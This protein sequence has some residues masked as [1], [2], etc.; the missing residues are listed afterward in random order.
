MHKD[1]GRICFSCVFACVLGKNLKTPNL[2]PMAVD[3]IT[4]GGMGGL[5]SPLFIRGENYRPKG[6]GSKLVLKHENFNTKQALLLCFK[7]FSR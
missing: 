7:Y 2:S 4:R 1:C 5:G 6:S 3:A